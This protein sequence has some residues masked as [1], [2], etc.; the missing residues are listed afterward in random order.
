MHMALF[1]RKKKETES[2][3]AVA[4]VTPSGKQDLSWVLIKPR[5]TEK[6]T[7]VG[8]ARAYVFNVNEGANKQ[9]IAHAI[10]QVY[11]VR[12]VKVRVTAIKTKSI[13]NARTG[14][15]GT[16]PGGKKA[17]IYL[18]EGDSINLV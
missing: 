2:A 12:P 17:Y 4:A 15:M 3:T 8:V 10:N 18:K 16:K 7:D 11:K 5:I 13:R 9:Q 1:S 6:A 14:K